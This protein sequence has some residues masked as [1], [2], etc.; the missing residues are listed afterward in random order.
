MMSKLE[1]GENPILKCGAKLFFAILERRGEGKYA[2][3]GRDRVREGIVLK[4]VVE[5]LPHR[6][7]YVFAQDISFAHS[8][9]LAAL[10][11]PNSV[12]G[13]WRDAIGARDG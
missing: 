11:K 5:S 8:Q 1:A 3:A 2:R 7:F 13:R 6:Q 10:Y 12:C 9:L 4:L